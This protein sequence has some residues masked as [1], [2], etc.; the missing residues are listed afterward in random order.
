MN[1]LSILLRKKKSIA[2]DVYSLLSND[3]LVDLEVIKKDELRVS[4]FYKLTLAT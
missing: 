4:Y 3:K 2:D 1:H